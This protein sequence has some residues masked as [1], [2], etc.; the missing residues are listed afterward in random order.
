[1]PKKKFISKDR[2]MF[3]HYI[4]RGLTKNSEGLSDGYIMFPVTNSASVYLINRKGEVVHEWKGNYGVLGAYLNRD[5]SLYQNAIDPDFPVFAGGGETGRLQKISW[6]S[7]IL[8]DF[9]YANEE[10]HAHHDLTIMPNGHILAIA[11]EAKTAE[12]VLAAGRKPSLIP[13][14]GLWPDKIIEIEPQGERGGKI[15][16]QW[17]IW[18]HLIQNYDSKK[19]NYGNPAEHPELLDFNV[20]DTL[21]KPISRDSLE[22]LKA[23]GKAWRNQT[24]ENRGSD[25]YHFNAIKYNADLDQILFSS[26]HLSEIFIIDHSATTQEAA[27]HQGGKMGKGGDFIYRWGNPKNYHRGDTTDQKLFGQHNVQWIE[28]GKP[29]AGHLLVFNNDI[30]Y[31]DSMNYSAIFEIVPPMDAKGNYLLTNSKTFGPEKPVWTYVAPDSVSF[32]SSFISGAHRMENGNTFIN[33]GAKG[34]FFEVTKEGKLVWEYLNPY[35]GEIRKPNGD[36]IVFM[37]MTY[38]EFRA[39]FIPA[40]HPALVNRK[41]EP[42]NPQPKIFVMPSP[43]SAINK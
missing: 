42:L 16:W 17:H 7:K 32:Y 25:V 5:G 9:E 13:K 31:R 33:E 34:R 10:S 28:K 19:A 6:D 14:A 36:P 39:T 21:P 40:S 29:G 27:S 20:G 8:W 11:W 22:I 15:V 43:P 30:H 23:Q 12:Q 2:N 26:P 41:L 38:S 18:D 24:P 1:M 3:G 4:P 35:R 37:P